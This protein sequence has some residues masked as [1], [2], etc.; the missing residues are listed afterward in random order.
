MILKEY[1]ESGLFIYMYFK[2]SPIQAPEDWARS[3]NRHPVGEAH[4]QGQKRETGIVNTLL[5]CF[6]GSHC[7][8]FW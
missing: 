7:H 6:H 1:I 3:R 2:T 5:I 8:L 4:K